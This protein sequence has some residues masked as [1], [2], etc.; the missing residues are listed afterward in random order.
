MAEPTLKD[1]IDQ[2]K[3]NNDSLERQNTEVSNA[4]IAL[5]NAIKGLTGNKNL[6][7]LD[8]LEA[9]REK[10]GGRRDKEKVAAGSGGKTRGSFG[11]LGGALAGAGVGIGA[12]GAG[13]GAFFMGLAGSEAIMAKFGGGDNLKKMM[14]NLSEGLASFD[15][16]SLI[17]LGAVLGAGALFGAVPIISGMG[18]GIGVGAMGFGIGAFFTGL[19]AGDMAISEMESTGKNLSVFMGNF[20]DG[21]SKLDNKSMIMLGGLLAAGGGF[22]ALFGVGKAAKGAI[23]MALLG[24]GIAG[25]FAALGAGDMA[26]GAMEATGE[27]LS[28]LI[29]NLAEGLGKLDNESLVKV[30]GLLGA[31]GAFGAF[32]GIKKTAKA[33]VGMTLFATGFAAGLTALGAIP[34]LASKAGLG[35]GGSFK[36][37]MTNVGEG[38]GALD[39]KGFKFIS[40]AIAAGGALGALFGPSTVAKAAVGMVAVGIGIGGF[41]GTL[42]GVTDLAG[43]LGATGETFKVIMTNIGKGFEGFNAVEPG[44]LEKVGALAGVGPAIAGFVASLGAAALG[45]KVIST[46]KSVWGF[47]SGQDVETNM[48]TARTNQIQAI[49]D[50]LEPLK[51]LDVTVADKM[52]V[53]SKALGGFARA[54]KEIAGVNIEK[55]QKGFRETA[56]ALAGQVQVLDALANGGEIPATGFFSFFKDSIKFPQ[57][58]I[59]NPNL[60]LDQVADAIAKAQFVLGQRNSPFLLDDNMRGMS[61]N[62]AVAARSNPQGGGFQNII[63]PNTTNIQNA[64]TTFAISANDVADMDAYRLRYGRVGF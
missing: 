44:V 42:A 8:N 6:K 60:K 22:A 18:A 63:A 4:V 23:G 52:I 32:F 2:L 26:I 48:T 30:I 55:F 10:R 57:G 20:A 62:D 17:A 3:R 64:G 27:S 37:L 54:I 12:M 59:L 39:N 61:L 38:L 9:S 29:G 43:A 13:M 56:A 28:T 1:V 11:M 40:G 51:G 21:L 16:R 34:E 31:G 58:G 47:L 5:G 24:G 36:K 14:V 15:N 35:E 50:S 7:A 45:D 49:V 46:F 41:L 25:F 19:A 33:T 53:I